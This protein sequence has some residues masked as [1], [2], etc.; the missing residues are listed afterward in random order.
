M[1]APHEKYMQQLIEIEKEVFGETTVDFNEYQ[2]TSLQASLRR[3]RD[4]Y[5]TTQVP[6][7][8]GQTTNTDASSCTC[9]SS[10]PSFSSTLHST[11]TSTSNSNNHSSSS[12]SAE[13]T[14]IITTQT[15]S[16]QYFPHSL[17]QLNLECIS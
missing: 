4:Q 11:T 8:E 6:C 16:Q 7:Q 12:N 15:S 5:Q 14:E 2:A 1:A 3:I 13:I 10:T 17:P 9:L